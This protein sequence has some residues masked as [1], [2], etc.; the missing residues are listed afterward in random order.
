M[1][2]GMSLRRPCLAVARKLAPFREICA[3]GPTATLR[4]GAHTIRA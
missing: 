1:A 2:L 3:T 4:Y